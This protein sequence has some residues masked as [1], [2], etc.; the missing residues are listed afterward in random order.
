MTRFDAVL[1]DAGGVLVLPDPTV[2]APLLEPLGGTAE[3]EAHRRAHYAGMAAKSRAG[4]GERDWLVYDRAYVTAVGVADDEVDHAVEVLG[5]TRSH[6]L[7]RWPVPETVAGLGTL[8]AAGVPLGVVSNASGQIE[9]QL[10]RSGI[11]Q[12]GSG[13]GVAVRVVV[14]SHVV[15]VA[16]PDPAI[17]EFALGHFDGIDR[18]RIA[19]VGDSVTMDVRSA[20][21]AGLHPILID[22]YGDHPGAD[23]ETTTAVDVFA[24][25]L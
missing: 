22:P 20:S 19:Y 24:A 2:L 4:S 16:K 23:F 15:G 8:A 6:H 5:R 25:S 10:L 1:F 7:W 17:F 14:D 13:P 21:A 12:V 9:A 11:C 18:R 3:I